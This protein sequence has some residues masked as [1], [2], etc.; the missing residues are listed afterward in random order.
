[1]FIGTAT[2]PGA[3]TSNTTNFDNAPADSPQA[4]VGRTIRLFCE[5]GSMGSGGEEVLHLPVIVEAAESSPSAAAAAAQQIRKFLTRE[6]ASKPYVQYNSIMLIRILSDNPGPSFTR[7]FDKAFVSTVKELLRNCKDGSTQQILRETLDTLEANKQL[8]EGMEGLIQMWRKE[9]GNQARLS[10]GYAGGRASDQPAPGLGP[11]A[12]YVYRHGTQ[13]PGHGG[14]QRSTSG[15]RRLPPP[16]ELASRIEEARNTAKILLQLIQST[17]SEEVL[18]NELIREFADRCQ[19]AQRSMQ[20]YINCDSPPPDDDTMLTLIETN[21]QLSLATTRYQRSILTARRAL[22]VSPSPNADPTTMSGGPYAPPPGPPTQDE[23]LFAS[24]L[25]PR[26]SNEQSAFGNRE[27]S[28]MPP[29]DPPPRQTDDYSAFGS[30]DESYM[31]PSGPPPRQMNDFSAFGSQNESYQPTSGPPRRQT[32]ENSTSSNRDENHQ[33]PPGPPASMLAR[34]NSRDGQSPTQTNSASPA[35][36]PPRLPSLDQ[37]SDPFADPVEHDR[38]PAP[39]AF[40][41]RSYASGTQHPANRPHS[42]TFSIDAEPSYA[43]GHYRDSSTPENAYGVSPPM[44]SESAF[45]SNSPQRP[46]H[47]AWHNSTT[48]PSYIGRQTSAMGG[49]TMHG[50]GGQDYVPEIDGHSEVGRTERRSSG[51]SSPYAVSPVEARNSQGR[52]Y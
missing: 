4:N 32:N 9:K 11:Q 52:A 39:L 30:R 48:T 47:G 10:Q 31:P 26:Q 33:P 22:G 45:S 18:Q 25:P 15:H 28:Y 43:P 46:G 50:A 14:Q 51:T 7:N 36:Q 40:D 16:V 13:S 3:S 20:G 35:D 24:N 21:E 12:D 1:M 8:Q 29:T 5:S 2:P 27:E 38:N 6:W 42:Q 23:N 37:P 19:S 34:L 41:S 17:P 49:L 44:Q